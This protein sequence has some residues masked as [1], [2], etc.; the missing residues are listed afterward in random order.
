MSLLSDA[1]LRIL[2]SVKKLVA[3]LAKFK[4][5]VSE[6]SKALIIVLALV[7]WVAISNYKDKHGTGNTGNT[8]DS[9]SSSS[10]S[11]SNNASNTVESNPGTV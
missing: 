7:G 1:V 11:S 2:N 4:N 8:G 6:D 3:V 5:S 9:S 10:S